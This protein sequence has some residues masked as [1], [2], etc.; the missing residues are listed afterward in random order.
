MDIVDSQPM[1]YLNYV[2]T[3]KRTRT[4]RKDERLLK[5]YLLPLKINTSLNYKIP[6]FMKPFY[7]VKS[8]AVELML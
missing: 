2:R 5:L 4:R 6:Y 1:P 7:R 3:Y 8:L